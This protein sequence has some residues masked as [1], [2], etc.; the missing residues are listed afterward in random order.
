MCRKILGIVVKIL[1]LLFYLSFNMTQQTFRLNSSLSDANF[2]LSCENV[3]SKLKHPDQSTIDHILIYNNH[4]KPEIILPDGQKYVWYF[5]IGSMMNPISLFLRD[6]VPLMSFP[7]KCPDYKVTFREP[8]GMADTE[9]CPNAEFHGVVH[10][11]SN[12]RMR[13]LDEIELTYHRIAVSCIDYQEQSH[14]V[15]AYK[16]NIDNLSPGLP[17]ERYLD[18]IVKGCEYYKVQ[19]EYI[20]QLKYEQAVIPRRQPHLFQSFKVP[21]DVF[22]SVEELSQH[23]GNDS[24]LP[25]WISINGKILEYQG[26]PS[27]DDSDYEFQK[28]IYTFYTTKFGGCEATLTIARALYEPLYKIPLSENDL[29]SQHRAQIEDD[30]CH[31]NTNGQNKSY[32]KP[33][34]RLYTPN[35]SL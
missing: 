26:L 34:G 21:D 4:E 20:D 27:A 30:F 29:C 32:W 31:R 18:V 10:L 16:M 28:K 6:I 7:A 2:K 1:L 15:Y 3:L 19:S 24:T 5:S 13:H 17:S 8:S 11:L 33:I 23:N 14:T 9:A 12:E 22:Y 25:L 35:N